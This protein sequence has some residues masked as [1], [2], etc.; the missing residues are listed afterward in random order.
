MNASFRSLRR[1]F[2]AGAL[3]TA[4]ISAGGC[5]TVE[6]VAEEPK[7]GDS[8]VEG[9]GAA[10]GE[11]TLDIAMGDEAGP[12]D[13]NVDATL[14]E[15]SAAEF[16]NSFSAP[17][18]VPH[19]P[20]ALSHGE[21]PAAPALTLQPVAPASDVGI[22][23]PSSNETEFSALPVAGGDF[24]NE[25]PASELAAPAASATEESFAPPATLSE[26]GIASSPTGG[27]VTP[28]VD[29][30]GRPAVEPMDDPEAPS[31][32]AGAA[33]AGAPG[34][35]PEQGVR[36]QTSS[37][38]FAEAS[39]GDWAPAAAPADADPSIAAADPSIAAAD[40]SI[41]A[42]EPAE[43]VGA[44]VLSS[45]DLAA[46]PPVPPQGEVASLPTPAPT[47]GELTPP[48]ATT[49]EPEALAGPPSLREA[50]GAV[51]VDA[52]E[53]SDEI[54]SA[55]TPFEEEDFAPRFGPGRHLAGST[56]AAGAPES[57]ATPAASAPEAE[58]PLPGVLAQETPSP[59]AN[60][61][62]MQILDPSAPPPASMR[63]TAGP[64]ANLPAYD[65]TI[66]ERLSP[67]T[68]GVE[69]FTP[70]P[71]GTTDSAAAL[72][73]PAA[74]TGPR[75]LPMPGPA[76]DEATENDVPA[77]PATAPSGVREPGPTSG[78]TTAEIA[79]ASRDW[80]DASGSHTLKAAILEYDK[81][82]VRLETPKGERF[83]V[84][85][86]SLSRYDQGY[87]KGLA[88]GTLGKPPAE[89]TWTDESGEYSLTGEFVED[90]GDAIRIVR[91]DGKTFRIAKD[92]LADYDRGY[93]DGLADASNE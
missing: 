14:G 87:V 6:Q 73:G 71:E 13:L 78:S 57:I 83:V 91:Q 34:L 25:L 12:L 2:A 42:A 65:P 37:A 62:A 30:A 32:L 8:A 69:D 40:P 50:I 81:G 18:G 27:S 1:A 39:E 10:T 77:P 45:P 26:S 79:E 19:A 24:S 52:A 80:T 49:S 15:V 48:A 54:Q 59:A 88:E 93:V 68:I 74:G 35:S 41:A 76:R 47:L 66:G 64:N 86:S 46:Q 70:T 51:P 33:S 31:A 53:S 63:P 20:P 21:V 28:I 44:E 60:S 90:A 7:A 17:Q 16:S 84:S 22:P 92:E 56:P 72:P 58:E 5:F 4:T 38:D 85:L 29:P 67:P 89:R 43:S 55:G 3:A 61:L 11:P 23:A 82:E 9:Q 36:A 75:E